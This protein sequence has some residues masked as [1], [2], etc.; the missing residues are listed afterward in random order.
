[1]MLVTQNEKNNGALSAGHLQTAGHEFRERGFVVLSGLIDTDLCHRLKDSV[2]ADV[3]GIRRDASPTPHE[4]NTALGH[5]QLGLRRYAPY[6]DA[7]LVANPIIEHVVSTLLGPGAWLG[8]Y[9]GNV[10]CPGSGTQP[11]HAD[12][13]FA[14]KTESDAIRAGQS[15]PPPTTTVSCSVAL[16]DITSDTGATEIFPGTHHET[17][18]TTWRPGERPQNHPD[19]IEKWSPSERMEIPTGGVCIRDPR[20]WHRGVPNRD[21]SPRPMVAITYHSPLAKHWR[22]L[23]VE[24]SDEEQRRCETDPTLRKLD[25]GQLGDGRLVFHEN[26]RRMFDADNLHGIHRNVRFVED[27]VDHIHGAHEV[28]GA[29]VQFQ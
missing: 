21:A 5:L 20:M 8:F 16:T 25:D 27:A 4:R 17:A 2:L 15:W 23:L 18:V 22:G 3:S 9:N 26:T 6:V 12:R 13:P 11:L 29:R 7:A 19:L 14:W 10:N 28:G 1:M 24:M